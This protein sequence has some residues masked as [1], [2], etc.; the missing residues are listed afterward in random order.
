MWVKAL[1][2]WLLS[3]FRWGQG[4][5]APLVDEPPLPPVVLPSA[6]GSLYDLAAEVAD[7]R[8]EVRAL[9]RAMTEKATP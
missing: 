2:K 1:I 7:L 6:N 9:R 8:A 4:A 3:L 5:L